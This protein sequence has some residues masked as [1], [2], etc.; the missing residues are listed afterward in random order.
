M[1][2]GSS[3]ILTTI[4]GNLVD[5]DDG[6]GLLTEKPDPEDPNFIF[7]HGGSFSQN[8]SQIAQNTLRNSSI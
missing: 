8:K 7:G 4:N 6:P 3:I 1:D 5:I 2:M